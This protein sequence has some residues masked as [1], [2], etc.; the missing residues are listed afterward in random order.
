MK[1]KNKK[2]GVVEEVKN[3]VVVEQYKNRPDLWH[4]VKE[5]DI[6]D[7]DKAKTEPAEPAEDPDDT[8]PKE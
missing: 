4:P 8:E 7:K 6:K 1:F 2:S 3:K 5:K